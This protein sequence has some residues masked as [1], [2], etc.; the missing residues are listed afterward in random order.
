M[1]RRCATSR[2]ELEKGETLALVG[3]SGS[4][5][6]VTALSI[7]QLLPYPPARHGRGSSITFEGQ[8]LVGASERDAAPH[9]RQ[10]HRHGV[11]GADDLAQPAA[12]DREAGHRDAASAQA[13]RCARGA[14]AR[15][16]E[17]LHLVGLAEAE[18]RLDAYPHQL[19]GGQRQRVMIAMALANEPDIL[20]ADEPT[21]ALDV[22]IQAQILTLLKDLQA[23]FGMALLLITHDL[24]IVRKMADR[25]AVM[26]QGEIVER[27][28]APRFSRAPQHPYTRRLLAA[29]PKGEPLAVA[30]R[31]AT[32]LVE[33]KALK[34]WF[35]IKTGVLR[36]TTGYVKAVDGVD[37]ALRAGETLGVVGESGSGKTTLGL[38]LSAPHRQRPARSAS[39]ASRSIELPRAPRCGRCGA[40]CRSCSRTRS[41]ACRP[42]LSVGQIVEEGLKV[43]RIG[44]DR[45][46][47]A[48]I[49]SPRR[50]RRSGSIP[51]RATAIRTNSRAA[52]AS[53][54]PSPARSC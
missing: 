22:T 27:G 46:E 53:A 26:T 48:A 50:S 47:R 43:H 14:R 20:I 42:R 12:H 36:R 13:H 29:E 8:E 40:R 33:T 35:P 30:P 9:P 19:S 17:L 21:T 54:S 2:F 1:S 34:V 41:R 38:A 37:L 16:I 45:A 28:T 39:T 49:S 18:R 11:P 24:T 51:S 10:P 6:S 15:A 25:V 7:L 31:A 32:V 23:R 52:S 44:G 5:K 3:E 4:G